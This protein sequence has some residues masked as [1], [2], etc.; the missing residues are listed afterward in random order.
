VKNYILALTIITQMK[1]ASLSSLLIL[2]SLFYFFWGF[3]AAS[4][5]ILIP[6]FKEIFH[7]TQ[8]KSQLVDLA[9]YIAYFFGSLIYF[10]STLL[11]K[12]P[13][14][15]MGYKKG[16]IL[17]LLISAVGAIGFIPA[18]NMQSYP[19]LLTC[20]FIIGLGF[21]LQQIVANP[22]V[23]ALGSPSTGSHRLNLTGGVNS[24]GTTIGPVLLSLALFGQLSSS[25]TPVADIS[26]VKIPSI[27]LFS[28]F[29]VCATIIAFSSLP[30]V[31]K[32]EEIEK[33]PGALKYPQLTLGMLAIFFYVGV[34]V[35]IQSNLGALLKLP[36]IKG[37]TASQISPYISLYWGSLMIGRWRGSITVFNLSVKIRTVLMTIIPIVAFCVICGVN[38][39]RNSD[40]SDYKYYIPYLL[41]A[42]AAF[43]IGQEKPAR[44]LILFSCISATLM[45]VGLL[46]TGNVALFSF[47][48][49]G[50][51]CSVMW[52]CIFALAI[53]GLGK[54]T[55]QGSSLL[56]MMILGGAIIPPIQG[57]IVDH[58]GA[59]ISYIVPVFCF[60]YLAFYGWKVRHIFKAQGMDADAIV[61]E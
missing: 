6:L 19:M 59:H 55:T 7:L 48:S 27:I 4:N 21:T 61:L 26:S 22:F 23:I 3:V 39:L 11:Y 42:I 13:L 30:E 49:G 24:F 20:M 29:L 60:A 28:M 41:L 46:T 33:K 37:I 16:L 18:T 31:T 1:K 45:I 32:Q 14:L 51:Y 15:R 38:N 12:D 25:Y 34:E 43:F 52:P 2:I 54:Y 58:Y 40:I 8:F 9:F 5:G 17:G 47:I 50:L 44:T 56:I 53:T 35:T 36:E 57:L 10:F